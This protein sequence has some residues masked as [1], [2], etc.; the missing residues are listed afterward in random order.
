MIDLY[1]RIGTD[2]AE[3]ELPAIGRYFR[4]RRRDDV[5]MLVG[6]DE[7]VDSMFFD[8]PQFTLICRTDLLI[9]TRNA[10]ASYLAKLYASIG[11]DFVSRL[12]GTFAVII[13]DHK[14]RTLKAWATHS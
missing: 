3:N 8:D 14:A 6:G 1:A 11:D 13:H 4:Q 10:S 7:P 5:A 2:A 9:P 12:H